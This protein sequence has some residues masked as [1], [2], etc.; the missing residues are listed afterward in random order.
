MNQSGIVKKGIRK[1]QA[2]SLESTE[3]WLVVEE[4][5]E[6]RLGLFSG[7][8]RVNISV[9]VTMRTPGADELLAAGFLFSERIINS[10]EQI[11]TI[12]FPKTKEVL[13]QGNLIQFD[14]KKGVK[15]DLQKLKRN[16]YTTSSCGVCGKASIEAVQQMADFGSMK[17]PQSDSLFPERGKV[18][19]K[20]PK[21]LLEQQSL[22]QQTGGIHAA[23]LFDQEANLLDLQED[24]G[25]HNALDKLIGN[26]FLKNNFPLSRS[27]FRAQSG[28]IL[29]VSGRIGFELVQ[30]A[31]MAGIS[32]IA[33][34]GAP[35]SLAVGLAEQVG[36]TV[37]GFLKEDRFNVYTKK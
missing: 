17:L 11:E 5:L 13:A 32:F 30:K 35:T 9:A 37:V 29:L 33:A 34:V 22:F 3:D 4:P 18:I 15:V 31:A 27:E 24:V 36:M 19:A 8:Q 21:L 23:A 16:F 10:P 1:W 6:I 12:H 20:L 26:A 28:N 25:R 2:N 14:L 7:E